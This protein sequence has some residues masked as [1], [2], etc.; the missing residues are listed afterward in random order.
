MAD[1]R[2]R[3][4]EIMIRLI[5]I[6]IILARRRE[7]RQEQASRRRRRRRQVWTREWL[8]RRVMF[9]QYDT[10]LHELNREDPRCYKNFLRVD[11]DLFQEFVRRVGP[12]ITKKT[13]N[14][15][16]PLDPGLKLAI[17]LRHMATGAT[18]R[19]LM[20]SFRVADNTIS[21]FIPTVLEA[22]V[23]TFQAE[24]MPPLIEPDEWREVSIRF[25]TKWNFPHACGALDGKHI[26][27]KAPPNSGS[28]YHNYKGFFSM[29]LLALADADYKFIWVS[30]AEYGSA[31][32]CQVFNESEL[33]ELVE[34]GELGFPDPE[35]LPGLTENLPYFFLG[36]EGFPLRTW[37]MK[38]YS[39]M[40][41]GHDQRIFN[42]RLS[43]ARRVVENAFGI[44]ANKF[45]CLLN[46][47]VY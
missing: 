10:L 4:L 2:I 34:D 39:R 21:T 8:K 19:E 11:A 7:G 45:Q 13:T 42:Y 6:E 1:D 5:D 18:F 20:Y 12:Q 15:R 28:L 40:G 17:T 30:V 43:R 36:D 24:V 33:R 37:M 38:P 29:I 16:E 31:S 14:W 26:P 27:I 46:A 3:E 23:D 9:G 47:T 22:I 25:N 44:L 41:L 32:D 35:P